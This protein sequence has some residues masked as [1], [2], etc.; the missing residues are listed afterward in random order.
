MTSARRV[1]CLLLAL[2]GAIVPL[3]GTPASDRGIGG[4][5]GPASGPAISDRGIGGTGIVG[6][7]TGFGSVMV[8]G[9]EIAYAPSTP[10]TVDGVPDTSAALRVGQLAA[11]VASDDHGLHAVDI[12]V[13]HEVSG[14]VTSI[15]PDAG[16]RGL[17]LTVAGQH[18]AIGPATDGLRTLRP[19]EWIAVS[20]LRQP[21]GVIAASRIDQRMPGVVLVRGPA[22]PRAGGWQIGDLPIRPP[23]GTS[24]AP[25]ENITARG[26]IANGTLSVATASPDVLGANPA[27]YFGTH[28]RRMVIETYVSPADGHV[29]VGQ[30]LLA[31]AAPGIA[32]PV[33]A[34]RAI[35]DLE[36]E[37]HGG[38]VA[39]HLRGAGRPVPPHG[40]PFAP[41]RH[42]AWAPH[43]AAPHPIKPPPYRPHGWQNRHPSFGHGAYMPQR[44]FGCGVWGCRRSYRRP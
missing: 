1:A 11:L 42:G 5:G 19:G 7:I 40:A 33:G 38:F 36:R 32:V 37:P 28:V 20:G 3:A 18:V 17:M 44:R 24:I 35:V 29:R 16:S 41:E 6:V 8:N 22:V 31:R 14:P 4:T 9:L 10:L 25:G 15:S 34:H 26:E 2:W 12:A 30:G 27:A 43:R 13:R 39:T 21:D 23:Q